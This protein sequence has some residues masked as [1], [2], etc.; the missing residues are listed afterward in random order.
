[1][2]RDGGTAGLFAAR[3]RR[4]RIRALVPLLVVAATVAVLLTAG[5]L[6]LGTR[7]LDVRTVAV[8]G[9]VTLDPAAVRSAAAVPLGAPLAKVDVDRVATRVRTLG[10]VAEVHI[11]R[12]WPHTLHVQV[13]ER[14]PAAV[15]RKGTRYVVL[16]ATGYAYL[17]VAHPPT[18][19]PLV[20]VARPGP[21][22][23]TTRSVLTV[24]AALTPELRRELVRIS[25]PTAEQVTL[26]LRGG[27]T[28]FWGDAGDSA[29]KA[30]VATAL[31]GRPGA[32]IDVSAP[33]VVTVK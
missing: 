10:P 20:V 11:Y 12:S 1:M 3:A 22:D 8:E 27:R 19:A 23:R 21:S 26:A 13:V 14:R 7:V 29:D 5:W 25:A 30:T 6:V 4:R 31:L 2:V 32:R 16:D 15:V 18:G 24:A 17:T 9:V 28:V 33:D